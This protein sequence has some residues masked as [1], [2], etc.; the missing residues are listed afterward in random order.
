MSK[1]ILVVDDEKEIRT[2]LKQ[3]FTNAG[4]DVR[5]ASS[6]ESALELLE[7][8]KIHVM[9]LDLNLPGM[10]GIE[11]CGKIKKM[12]PMA[13][14]HAITGYA[15]MF[16]LADCR[17]AGFDDYFTKPMSLKALK[18]VAEDAFIKIDRWK[19]KGQS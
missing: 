11:L 13:I 3:A 17:D 16:E 1:K 9:F 10:N 14:I 2:L 18:K 12:L 5:T 15:S 19:N 4:Y 6:A 7:E 8:E